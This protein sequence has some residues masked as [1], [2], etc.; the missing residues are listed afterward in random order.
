MTDADFHTLDSHI[1]PELLGHLQFLL[2]F[3]FHSHTTPTY[4]RRHTSCLLQIL[5]WSQTSEVPNKATSQKTSDRKLLRSEHLRTACLSLSIYQ[6][7]PPRLKH[8]EITGNAGDPSSI[9]GSGRFPGKGNGYSLQYSCL[10]NCMDG[11]AWRATVH[12]VTNSQTQ[13]S[14]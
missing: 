8:K 4:K 2:F 12:G 6:G 3:L 7:F 13:L 10:E 11:G 1:C 9:P 5:P 14:D